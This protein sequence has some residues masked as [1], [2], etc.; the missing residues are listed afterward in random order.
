MP[1]RAAASRRVTMPVPQA[2]SSRLRAPGGTRLSTAA[3]AAAALG[4]PPREASYR[5]ASLS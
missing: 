2:T 3:A 5:S 4:S 1:L